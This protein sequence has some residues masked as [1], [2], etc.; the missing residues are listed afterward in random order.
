MLNIFKFYLCLNEFHLVLSGFAVIYQ[1][2]IIHPRLAAG[3]MVHLR[4]KIT[5][6]IGPDFGLRSPTGLDGLPT[7]AEFHLLVRSFRQ[8]E[9]AS[10]TSSGPSRQS[11][12][13]SLSLSASVVGGAR[14][15]RKC[16]IVSL[17]SSTKLYDRHATTS[18]L[19]TFPFLLLPP[20]LL[21]TSLVGDDL[22]LPPLA[23]LQFFEGGAMS[24]MK[25]VDDAFLGV[26]DKPYVLC[27][28]P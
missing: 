14:W 1:K 15:R 21:L 3:K 24:T 7:L 11:N 27:P 19:P 2:K 5:S 6:I 22:P 16:V 12:G 18:C 28:A 8:R 17:C 13:A 4:A 20:L 23:V 26:G 25:G 9:R 10:N